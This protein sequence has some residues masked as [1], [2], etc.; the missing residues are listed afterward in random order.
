[1]SKKWRKEREGREGQQELLCVTSRGDVH[2]NDEWVKTPS[3]ESFLIAEDKDGDDKLIIFG[4]DKNI[5]LLCESDAI[6]V[7]GTFQTCPKLFYQ[8]FI[9]HAF[10]HG[11][12]YP[13]IY[14]FLPNKQRCTYERAMN[15][16]RQKA[17]VLQL[18]LNPQTVVGD[19]N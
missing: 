15:L 18:T 9:M 5:E 3:G 16:V 17:D 14:A 13:L 4:T 19:L 7:D 2:F 11:K 12:Q 6:Y 8:I 10:K 1:M